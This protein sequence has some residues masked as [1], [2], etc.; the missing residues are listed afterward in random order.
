MYIEERETG[1][2]CFKYW[3]VR[4]LSNCVEKEAWRELEK[5]PKVTNF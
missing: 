2:D 5:N 1:K 4:V 3:M